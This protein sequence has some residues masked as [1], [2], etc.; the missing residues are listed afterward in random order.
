MDPVKVNPF[1][2]VAAGQRA[3]TQFT[4]VGPAA[5]F[6]FILIMGGT[7]FDETK[8]DAIKVMHSGKTLFPSVPGT[9]IRDI[10]KY[11]G[12]T[13]GAGYL[14]IL[15]GDPT[16]RTAAGQHVGSFDFTIW[17]GQMT[18]Q[19]DIAATAVAPTLDA[20]ALL[21]PPKGLMGLGYSAAQVQL[22][23]A[24]IETVITEPAAV[25][26]KAEA[27]GI[28]SDAGA[29]LKKIAFFHAHVTQLD[30]KRQGFDIYEFVD[31]ALAEAIQGDLFT[32]VPQAGLLTYDPIADGNYS[33]AK[34]TVDQNGNPYN[35]Q[36]RLT[37]SAADT[38]YAYS[39]VLTVL[40]RL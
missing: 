37:T 30:I 2:N 34:G 32:R 40:P 15:F 5:L 21:S 31:N 10:V 8:I 28:G 26:N 17:P 13:Y 25:A 14:P 39:D 3:T 9:R 12:Q 23:R 4:P 38:I 36:M 35:Y 24:L 18:L 16:A 27:I 20:Y 7:T 1:L 19:V 33:E 22:H 6:G 29:L 11:E